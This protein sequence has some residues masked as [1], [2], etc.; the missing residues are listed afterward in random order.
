M[1]R[2]KKFLKRFP[3]D[4][5]DD[6]VRDARAERFDH[7]KHKILQFCVDLGIGDNLKWKWNDNND[8]T[9]YLIQNFHNCCAIR[10]T[11]NVN[12]IKIDPYFKV[13]RSNRKCYNYNLTSNKSFHVELSK[14][15]GFDVSKPFNEEELKPNC[16]LLRIA[17]ELHLL[18][19]FSAYYT[20]LTMLCIHRWR[21]ESLVAQLTKDVL[22]YLLKNFIKE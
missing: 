15:L 8:S 1:E 22:L 11:N 13:I 18:L 14:L 7:V 19:Y 17:N 10:F 16:P 2:V 5:F 6:V 3:I 20:R 9:L 21:K 4:V 12:V